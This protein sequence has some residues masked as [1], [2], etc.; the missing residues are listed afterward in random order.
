MYAGTPVVNGTIV[1]APAAFDTPFRY[2]R[3]VEPSH[4]SATCVHAFSG[5]SLTLTM[6]VSIVEPSEKAAWI[7]LSLACEY[8]P[9]RMSVEYWVPAQRAYQ[10]LVAPVGF[11]HNSTV[12]VVFIGGVVGMLTIVVPPTAASPE[13]PPGSP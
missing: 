1:C 6:S 2:S 8:T 13:T 4:V 3:H 10:K 9:I 7:L 5:R 11:T 12:P